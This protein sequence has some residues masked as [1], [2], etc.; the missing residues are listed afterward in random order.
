MWL[1]LQLDNWMIFFFATVF[2]AGLSFT[3]IYTL[4][5]TLRE[6]FSVSRMRV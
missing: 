6:R 2:A 3:S 4:I 1:A 5:Q